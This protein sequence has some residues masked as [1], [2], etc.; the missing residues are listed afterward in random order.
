MTEKRP[1]SKRHLDLAIERA[2]GRSSNPLQIRG[3]MANTIIGQLLPSGAVKGG[4]ALKLRYGY[5]MTRFTTDLDTARNAN[6]SEYTADLEAALKKGWNG[7]TGR[8]VTKK[9]ASPK[10][11][12]AEYVMKPY[13]VKLEYNGKSWIT[14]PLEIGHDEIGDTA[15]PDFL[16]TDDVVSIFSKLS[17]PDPM[18]VPLLP[19]HHQIAQK[20]HALS[21]TK[22]ERAHDLID[23]QLIIKRETITYPLLNATCYRLFKSRHQQEWPPVITKG[24]SWDN[25]YTSQT[26][27]LPVIKNV[28]DALVWVNSLISEICR[29]SDCVL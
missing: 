18:P 11:I 8:L 5:A 3:I 17:F 28:T 4:S 13:E 15:Q 6:L 2:F 19:I 1:N 23:L 25:L 12:P 7:F 16:I 27:D 9:P 10:N 14:V 26:G 22:S 21:S 20:L 24:A 29:S